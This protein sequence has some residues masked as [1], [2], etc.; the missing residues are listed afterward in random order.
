MPRTR[1]RP[2]SRGPPSSPCDS[3]RLLCRGPEMGA[4][5]HR[6]F[7][8]WTGIPAGMNQPPW[9]LASTPSTGR[10]RHTWSAYGGRHEP[11]RN[12]SPP[13]L[14]LTTFVVAGVAFVAVILIAGAQSLL[15]RRWVSPRR[16]LAVTVVGAAG[17]IVVDVL[18][19]WSGAS[20]P[21][22]WREH[23]GLAAGAVVL[24]CSQ[25]GALPRD[26]RRG[27]WAAVQI[28][29]AV[30]LALP[31]VPTPPSIASA[32]V[33]TT[34]GFLSARLLSNT[35]RVRAANVNRPELAH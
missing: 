6:D 1:K 35:L 28:V 19:V 15:V 23:A 11:L 17:A 10:I 34:A 25:L 32:V 27:A 2:R 22:A 7:A 29:A 30:A 33:C 13:R 18:F 12:R 5:A 14:R 24:F 4:A 20:A 3:F 8:E 16:W 21:E 31:F 9:S 26:A